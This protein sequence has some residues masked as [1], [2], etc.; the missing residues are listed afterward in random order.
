VNFVTT[1]EVAVFLTVHVK[2]TVCVFFPSLSTYVRI[3]P[4]AVSVPPLIVCG[5]APSIE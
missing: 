1:A 5:R 3:E 4:E 2:T